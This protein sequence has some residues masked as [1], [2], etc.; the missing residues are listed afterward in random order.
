M[1]LKLINSEGNRYS[2]RRSGLYPINSGNI[3]GAVLGV[4]VAI[5][6]LIRLHY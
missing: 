6:A 3:H 1:V 4:N 5:Q 2:E